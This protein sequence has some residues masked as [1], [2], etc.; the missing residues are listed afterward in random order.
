MN[1]KVVLSLHTGLYMPVTIVDLSA[2]MYTLLN[3][4]S[5]TKVTTFDN[6]S[7]ASLFQHGASIDEFLTETLYN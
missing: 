3:N 1:N 7:R 4:T 6:P 2:S 5:S